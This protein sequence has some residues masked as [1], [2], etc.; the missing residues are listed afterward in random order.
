MNEMADVFQKLFNQIER[1][2]NFPTAWKTCFLTPLHKKGSP[3]DPNN[4]RGLAVA[5]NISKFYTKALN[6]KLISFSE[7]TNIISPQQFGFRPD[8][9]TSDAIFVLR[10]SISSYK[11]T[12]NKP[13]FSCFVDFSKAFDSIDR[14][15]LFYKLGKIGING[16]L[17]KLIMDMYSDTNYIIKCNGNYSKPIPCTLG[18]KQ[19]CNL[20][21]LLFN[22]F[23]NDLHQIFDKNCQ[24]INI[25]SAQFN[26]L[27]FAD[28]LVL[29]S[30]SKLGLQNCLSKLG[31]YCQEWGLKINHDKTNVVIFNRPFNKKSKGYNFAVCGAPVEVKKSY[32][33]LGLEISSTGSF[34]AALDSLY[35]KALRA[36]FGIY[37]T[38][39]IYSDGTHI[40]LF[41][42]LF[43]SLVKPILLYGS[44]IWGFLPLTNKTSP[45][46]K[47]VNKFYRTLLGVPA[48][49][50]T[51]GV[52]VELGRFPIAIPIQS[53]LLK[54]WCRLVTLP[55]TRLVSR[56][57]WS[58]YK[59]N[60]NDPW[61]TTVK[62]IIAESG[63]RNLN[64]LWS[65][66]KQLKQI[67][68]KLISKCRKQISKK[69]KQSF[70]LNAVNEMNQQKK[71]S[72]F[73]KSK[74]TFEL[75]N[76]LSTLPIRFSRA[77]FAKLR[78]GTLKLEIETARFQGI[79][80][81]Q[82][83]CRLCRSGDIEDETHFLFSCDKLESIRTSP[84]SA[85]VS[86][87]PALQNMSNHEKL[88]FLY[89]NENLPQS[90]LN[91]AAKLLLNLHNAREKLLKQIKNHPLCVSLHCRTKTCVPVSEN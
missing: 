12:G 87:Q 16:K 79:E 73:R 38:L 56:C 64:F 83:K 55:R 1:T 29:L 62:S 63:Q 6:Q 35:K 60:V 89:F 20:S 44:E 8:F 88:M 66:Q 15:A 19:G 53:A 90:E 77:L 25:D 81:N 24:P 13:I 36:L 68:Q 84:I 85:L 54:Y 39:N 17:L 34:S 59:N 74:S 78:L 61:L 48:R 40:S 28:D 52:Q 30:E 26:S 50:S 4:Y 22:L 80:Q 69:Q 31:S 33:Y 9:R 47:I 5:N 14:S 21:P 10:S 70:L 32:C 23:I 2:S 58:L 11:K 46:T 37:S 82:R 49:A 51:I 91:S 71:L 27:S 65:S 67:D 18:V 75:S 3:G 86:K 45:L 41:L 76:Y 72:L 43:D 42:K 7:E 57:Y